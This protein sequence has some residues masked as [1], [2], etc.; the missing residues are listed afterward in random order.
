MKKTI[1]IA[2]ALVLLTSS[3]SSSFVLAQPPPEEKEAMT[4]LVEGVVG[5]I[6]VPPEGAA[7]SGCPYTPLTACLSCC[8]T[9]LNPL[10][11]ALVQV[12]S[13]VLNFILPPLDPLISVLPSFLDY[14]MGTIKSII[15]LLE[16]PELLGKLVT[17]ALP[18]I[19]QNPY[20]IIH[21]L[22]MILNPYSLGICNPLSFDDMGRICDSLFYE[23]SPRDCPSDPYGFSQ[24]FILNC[25]AACAAWLS[26]LR[27]VLGIIPGI[28]PVLE[29]MKEYL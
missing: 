16:D 1:G 23:L 21:L 2:L 4:S 27:G 25:S 11:G 19:L 13:I 26:G 9:P 8:F 10:G 28:I 12:I 6:L 7:R 24:A 18:I 17:I 20:S 22:D 5:N 3:V 14:L 29:P 15:P